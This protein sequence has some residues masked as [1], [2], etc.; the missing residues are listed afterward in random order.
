MSSLLGAFYW[1]LEAKKTKVILLAPSS[2]MFTYTVTKLI[3]TNL[4]KE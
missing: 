3:N 4:N 1:C 2:K